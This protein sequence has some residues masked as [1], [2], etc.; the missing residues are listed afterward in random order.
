M[1]ELLKLRTRRGL[2]WSTLALGVGPV[3]VGYLF[4]AV[5]QFLDVDAYGA[6]GG[7]ENLQGSLRVLALSGTVVAT[8]VGVTAGGADVQAGVFREL[9]VTGTPAPIAVRRA[10]PAVL[11]FLAPF[12]AARSPSRSSPRSPARIERRAERATARAE[13]RLVGPD[14]GGRGAVRPR[15]RLGPERPGRRRRG[16]GLA[17]RPRPDPARHRQGRRRPAERG[18]Q[19]PRAE[20]RGCRPRPWPCSEA[21]SSSGPS[22]CWAAGAWRTTTRDA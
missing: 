4:L 9:V 1:A 2:Y 15:H 20:W 21:S 17:A 5:R 18:P 7:V 19:R 12:L 14:L 3:V 11:L 6:A 10:H 16:P 8:V 22:R 13:R